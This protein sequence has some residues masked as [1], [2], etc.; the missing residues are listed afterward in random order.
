MTGASPAS[1]VQGRPLIPPR[2]AALVL[3]ILACLVLSAPVAGHDTRTA[4][5]GHDT[6]TV[7]TATTLLAAR[8]ASSSAESPGVAAAPVRAAAGASS[9]RWMVPASGLRDRPYR[10]IVL[11]AVGQGTVCTGFVVAPR[12]VVTAAHCL[13]R[14]ASGGDFRL[15]RGLP[16]SL[17]LYRGYSEAAGGSPFVACSVTRAW[18]HARFIRSGARDTR[19]GSRTHDYAVLTTPAGCRFPRSAVLPLWAPSTFDGRLR[20]GRPIRLAGYPSDPRF[21]R[22]NGLNLWRSQGRVLP[23]SDPAV[24]PVTGFVAQGM[25]GAP[26]W[27]SFGSSSPCGRSQCVV[28]IITECAVNGR[29][30]CRL[31][32]SARRA[33]RITPQVQRTIL[34]H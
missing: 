22:M 16:G 15:R 11:V 19:F 13:A 8:T 1:R 23:T 29:G 9:R 25:S 24:L 21:E 7:G 3:G 12:K 2:A 26:V 14:N 30:F 31:G 33:V 27:R 5:A 20:S 17:R 32:D 18:A 4:E 6:T 34:R 28:A 10:G